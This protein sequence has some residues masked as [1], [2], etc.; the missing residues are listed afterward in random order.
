MKLAIVPIHRYILHASIYIIALWTTI[1]FLIVAFQCRPLSL[2]W[3]PASGTGTCM[4]AI[5]I[6]RLGYAFSALDICSD[7]LY[8]FLPVDAM[9]HPD[10][11]EVEILDLHRP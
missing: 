9:G 8:A 6:T 3:N 7:F 10:D 4:A 5:A 2:A 11:L 1:T